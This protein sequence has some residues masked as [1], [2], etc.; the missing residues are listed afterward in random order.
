M[1]IYRG[2]LL[3][4]LER[5]AFAGNGIII[6]PPGV[7]KTFIL[8]AL[9]SSLV[10][11][12]SPC[13]YLPID[14]LDVETE[15]A[16]KAELG[17]KGDFIAYLKSQKVADDKTV[18]ILVIDAFDAARSETAQKFFLSLIHRVINELHGLWNVIV[19][20][21]TYDAKKS[22]DLQDLFHSSAESVPPSEFQMEEIHCRHFAIPKLT[23]E[24][25]RATA[26]T[27]PHLPAIYEQG[28]PDFKELLRI[29]FNLW[30]L[31]K[32]LSRDP[33]I[34]ELSSISS[35]VQLL[36]LFWKQ[37]VT[38]GPFGEDKRVFLSKVTQAMVTQRSLSVRKDEVN[39]IGRS[40]VWDSLLSAEILVNVSTTAQRVAFSHNMLFDYAVS[41]LLIEDEPDKVVE[42]VTED[43]S[44]PLFLRPSLNY[45][46]IRLWH[47]APDLFWKAFW[48]I[49]PSS[50]LH[51]RLFARLLPPSILANEAR[52]LEQLTP[53]FDSL[54]QTKPV[55]NEAVLRLLQAIRALKIERDELWV[56]FLG[57]TAK[58][59]HRDFAWDLAVITS[60][61]LDRAEKT[62]VQQAC[63]RISRRLLKWIWKEREEN[64]IALVEGLG[65]SWAVPLVA[66][67]FST[68]PKESRQL[69]KKVLSLTKEENFPIQFLYRLTDELDR[70]W[71]HDPEFAAL[72]YIAVFGHYETSE[73][74]THMGG[75]V[76]PLL[77][78]RR[79]DYEMC[80]YQ[81]IQHFPK[82]LRAAPLLATQAVIGCLDR[83]IIGRHIIGHLKEG[84]KLAELVEEF[85]F[86]GKAAHYIPDGSYI[87][88]EGEY[89]DEPIQMANE[90]YK[91]IGELASSQTRLAEL[92]SLL[93]VFCDNAWVAFF[94][95][96]LFETAAQAP[97][98]FAS[99]LFELCIA[100]PMQIESETLREL[101]VFLEAAAYEFTDEQL[102]QIEETIMTLPKDE[103]DAEHR[104]YL[105]HR[106]DRLLARIP[107]ELLKT[108]DAKKLR[109]AMESANRIPTNEPLVKF[110]SFCEPYSEEKWL[111]GQGAD[112]AR[113]ENQELQQF[114]A[115]L[116]KFTSEWQNKIPTSEVVR[117]ILPIAEELYTALSQTTVADKAVLNSAWSKLASSADTMS[118]AVNNPENDEFQFCREVLLLCSKHELPE[119]NPEY[120]SNYNSPSWSP[121]PRNEAAQGLPRIAA[122]KPDAN[123]LSAIDTLVHD[124]VPS[125]RFLIT[126]ELSR[127][128]VKEPDVFWRLAEDVSEHET[129]R[130][131]QQALCRTLIHV[132]AREEEKTTEVLNKLVTRTISFDEESDFLDSFVSLVIWLA[133]ARENGWAMETV[134]NFLGDPIPM[135]KPLERATTDAL[136]YITPQ[137]LNSSEDREVAERAISWLMK[138]IDAA[139]NGI[140]ELQTVP[141]EQWNEETQSKLRDLYGV[142]DEIIIRIYFAADV[143]DKKE[144][145]VSDEQRKD[146]YFKVK[147]LLEQVLAFAL[148]KK[149]GVMFAPTAHHFMELFNGVLKYDPKGVLHMAAGVAKSSKPAGYNLDSLAIREVVKLVEA[150]LADY[151]NEVR[152]GES[153][154]DLLSLLDI[155]AETGWPDALRLV[156]RLDE[157]FR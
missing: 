12:N 111:K 118:R 74:K 42:F 94:W 71:P 147:P 30:L 57:E 113:P 103:T 24:E 55:A 146:F 116:E 28:S 102:R 153:L 23:H 148:D 85:H 52:K 46:F 54:S 136:V 144:E 131:V 51:L 11:R 88:D 134:E 97:K 104:E 20:V 50:D 22:E 109:E 84:V 65:A 77:S 66:K 106:R 35:E 32:L 9:A 56:Q 99:R 14:K 154:Q 89:E 139:A 112:L 6:G 98:V 93:D 140:K 49:L 53:I 81:L 15:V 34:P 61:I 64:S 142:I 150:I 41:V 145:P 1:Q 16:L 157:V 45:Y 37:R 151:R 129:N 4:D 143:H 110:S 95:R 126:S 155:F 63:G 125:V 107:A 156:W 59:L 44:R 72:T 137:K 8:K 128:S 58:H 120:D 86:R 105:E 78:T 48:Y 2:S 10:D 43:P 124:K 133:L 130:V 138:A 114:F 117:S 40:G 152:D 70:I 26:E 119:P 135:A 33:N 87:W 82:F 76:L 38:D 5:F 101:G 73:E 149:N 83:F 67:T 31:E 27:I 96:R 127:L 39:V 29:P 47:T 123:I 62:E 79:Q 91:F 17:I 80:Q 3:K 141:N 19:S 36:G 13:L 25:V 92:D 108:D 122:C 7:G 68:D 60:D 75:I 90:L 115:P 121:A 100:R 69:L 21:R 18:G 132:V